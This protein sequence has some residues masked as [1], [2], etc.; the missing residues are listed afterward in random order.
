VQ[1]A[2]LER[3]ESLLVERDNLLKEKSQ[4]LDQV[5][6]CPNPAI[7]NRFLKVLMKG[8]DGAEGSEG[9]EK[10]EEARAGSRGSSSA[11]SGGS[12][13]SSNDD[14]SKTASTSEE[15]DIVVLLKP[16]TK[17]TIEHESS[18]AIMDALQS[19]PEASP[20]DATQG[21]TVISKAEFPLIHGL[22]RERQLEKNASLTQSGAIQPFV[23][24]DGG[25]AEDT[26]HA[27]LSKTD[28][29]SRLIRRDSERRMESGK[30]NGNT[31]ASSV[32]TDCSPDSKSDF[33]SSSITSYQFIR[34]ETQIRV[35]R[36]RAS[37]LTSIT[38]LLLQF[39]NNAKKQIPVWSQAARILEIEIRSNYPLDAVRLVIEELTPP[40]NLFDL[41]IQM[42]GR[43]NA[44]LGQFQLLT[45]GDDVGA[46]KSLRGSLTGGESSEENSEMK[47]AKPSEAVSDKKAIDPARNL[48]SEGAHSSA[49]P[50]PGF[51]TSSRSSRSSSSS[52]NNRGDSTVPIAAPHAPATTAAAAVCLSESFQRTNELL[53]RGRTILNR[54]GVLLERERNN[55]NRIRATDEAIMRTQE[56]GDEEEYEGDE[57]RQ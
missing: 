35:A 32:I 7:A 37:F 36:G 13:G 22:L 46:L 40:M 18:N 1:V 27:T 2:Q 11:P 9:V 29:I 24:P 23:L 44:A 4:M 8:Q 6:N 54:G 33:K 31:N 28:L 30:S 21:A 45:D 15:D 10:D 34:L 51:R 14:A 39:F 19:S 3:R 12:N 50:S 57:R 20:G 49:M 43:A 38:N 53:E 25:G 52:S 47:D 5:K 48:L 42:A 55:E 41:S 16:Q 56:M 26:P 17:A